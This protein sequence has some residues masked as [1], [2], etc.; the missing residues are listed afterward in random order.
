MLCC[1]AERGADSAA[2]RCPYQ[3]L[4]NHAHL[5]STWRLLKNCACL[6]IP[7]FGNPSVRRRG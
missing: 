3:L 4:V 1:A 6:M 2:A 5:L 7:P